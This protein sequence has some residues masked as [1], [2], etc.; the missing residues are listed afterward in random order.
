MGNLTQD[1]AQTFLAF[2]EVKE[3]FT[4]I[5]V[6]RFG[7]KVG[8]NL[9]A[10]AIG[11]NLKSLNNALDSGEKLFIPDGV[12]NIGGTLKARNLPVS[13]IGNPNSK[14]RQF[15]DV[16]LLEIDQ[17]FGLHT[18]YLQNITLEAVPS[19][20]VATAL[21]IYGFPNQASNDVLRHKQLGYLSNI[22]I[23]GFDAYTAQPRKGG[24]KRG[25]YV[26]TP[27]QMTFRDI[28]I[29]GSGANVD[30]IGFELYSARAAVDSF[31]QNIKI[32]NVSVGIKVRSSAAKGIEGLH[33]NH[34]L[35]AGSDIGI[36]IE[37]LIYGAPFYVI[38]GCHIS[39][40]KFNIRLVN[41][42]QGK[43]S[44]CLFYN[45]GSI[46]P[47]DVVSYLLLHNISD[48]HIYDN[49][50]LFLGDYN[51]VDPYGILL[52][53]T[54]DIM[55]VMNKIHDN[56]FALKA[57][58]NKDMVWQQ[59]QACVNNE[60]YHNR[61][62]Q[63]NS[64]VRQEAKENFVWSN[65]PKDQSDSLQE[66]TLKYIDPNNKPLG[67]ELDLYYLRAGNVI[68][69]RG[70]I[71]ES[72]PKITR[73]K[74]RTGLQANLQFSETMY[75]SN[76]ASL[77]LMQ[78]VHETYQQGEVITVLALD[79]T[80]IKQIG[81]SRKPRKTLYLDSTPAIP[82]DPKQYDCITIN[83]TTAQAMNI[84]VS[85]IDVKSGTEIVFKR[86]D[87]TSTGPININMTAPNQ[88][89]QINGAFNT[90]ISIPTDPGMRQLKYRLNTGGNFEL[91]G[92]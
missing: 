29:E 6:K 17:R 87:N 38:D 28:Q 57:G 69:T 64:S 62:E 66:I 55:S 9:T 45:S 16:N 24:F 49:S 26:E 58:S 40:R 15:E 34:C 53:A 48:W 46:I 65:Y 1:Q 36:D 80:N 75:L 43:I 21:T 32:G 7:V 11:Q 91:I 72:T 47:N 35:V 88:I 63:G 14:I 5:N 3:N 81:E 20:K 59:G 37:S 2:K 42:Q 12:I 39:S 23:T 85:I 18:P 77:S 71:I 90:T 79:E 27:N 33:L 76:S 78:G 19:C 50:G 4:G 82:V 61:R 30:D 84:P 83:N 51:V 70:N 60:I 68:V 67:C 73:I 74:M 25:I 52:S 89:Q 41:V 8:E 44:N 22:T 31:M 13:I 54:G 92:Y 10:L 86:Y 56:Y